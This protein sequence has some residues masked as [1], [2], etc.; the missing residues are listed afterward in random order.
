MSP[1]D[2]NVV[3]NEEDNNVDP[4]SEDEEDRDENKIKISLN[5]DDGD[6]GDDDEEDNDNDDDNTENNEIFDQNILKTCGDGYELD[7]NN[8]C[9]DIDECAI[10]NTG[11]QFCKNVHGGFECFCPDGFDLADDERTC[12]DINECEME[13]DY[14]ETDSQ[15][16]S[17]HSPCSHDCINTHGSY[18]CVCPENFHL[19]YDHRT[20]VRDFCEH[21]TDE[22]NKTKCSHQ[23]DD[24]KDGYVCKCPPGV[25]L[26]TDF[27]TCLVNNQCGQETHCSPGICVNMEDG[28]RCECPSGYIEKAKRCHDENECEIGNHQC[29]HDCK[30]SNILYNNLH[31]C[32][33]DLSLSLN[34]RE[35]ISLLYETRNYFHFPSLY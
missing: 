26:D 17:T 10:G 12:Q 19:Q 6:E 27:K 11:C 13:A 34:S 7:E 21:L 3:E 32:V 14:D 29:S 25:H 33:F 30:Y 20:C 4:R 8:R 16:T 9:V 35:E 1:I 22:F 2:N 18:L 31:I 28:Y 24:E 23:C 15:E 5:E